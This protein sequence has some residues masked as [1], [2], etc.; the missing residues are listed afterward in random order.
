MRFFGGM[1]CSKTA[2]KQNP[3][4]LVRVRTVPTFISKLCVSQYVRVVC[5]YERVLMPAYGLN[6]MRDA[7]VSPALVRRSCCQNATRMVH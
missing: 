4:E 5:M 6:E 7:Y 3:H 2:E 1:S